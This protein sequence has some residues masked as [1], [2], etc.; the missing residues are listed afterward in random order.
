MDEIGRETAPT[1]PTEAQIKEFAVKATALSLDPDEFKEIS[2]SLSSL[3][4]EAQARTATPPGPAPAQPTKDV[5]NT[6]PENNRE[7]EKWANNSKTFADRDGSESMQ[8][9]PGKTTENRETTQFQQGNTAGVDNDPERDKLAEEL[10]KIP[11]RKRIINPGGRNNFSR[12]GRDSDSSDYDSDVDFPGLN[13]RDSDY[14]SENGRLSTTT[15]D[16]YAKIDELD[17]QRR[18]DQDRP[19]GRGPA[20]PPAADFFT[21]GPEPTGRGAAG[22]PPSGSVPGQG[23]EQGSPSALS[24]ADLSSDPITQAIRD[25]VII[26]QNAAILDTIVEQLKASVDNADSDKKEALEEAQATALSL[27]GQDSSPKDIA[28]Y[29]QDEGNKERANAALDDP[30]LQK[31]LYEIEAAGYAAV[32]QEFGKKDLPNRFKNL[33]WKEENNSRTTTIMRDGQ[34]VCDL[35][36]NIIQ[37]GNNAPDGIN[38]Y[39]QIKFETQLEPG[40]QGPLHLSMA[41]QDADGN[42]MPKN[43]A[44]YFTAHYDESGKLTEVSTPKPIKF[45]GEGQDAIGYIEV[46]DKKYTLPV[47]KGNYNSMMTEVAR[48]QGLGANLSQDMGRSADSMSVGK[49]MGG[50]QL[51]V[52]NQ[53]QG[54]GQQPSEPEPTPSGNNVDLADK[55]KQQ[56]DSVLAAEKAKIE[57]EKQLAK[58][59][60]TLHRV[61]TGS[62]TVVDNS[63]KDFKGASAANKEQANK[64]HQAKQELSELKKQLD[65]N[66]LKSIYGSVREKA[67][68][69]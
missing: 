66:D 52:P 50:Q 40:K 47:T 33:E 8:S 69:D 45:A 46:G 15:S 38:Q 53:E 30:T 10:S 63:K 42:N 16:L 41:L 67:E 26:K 37:G 4:Q 48:N 55:F 59:R 34:P 29:L 49:D 28:Q 58:S 7:F 21:I 27:K 36:Q 24:S 12:S 19:P 62:R 25:H 44:V 14:D 57:V 11:R 61:K 54:A 43:G 39:R 20:T 6:R 65:Q 2:Q 9:D 68:R 51:S 13:D 3:Q 22:D 31:K 1:A 60:A 35:T 56:L 17:E 64:L 18:L 32:H 23:Q 5:N